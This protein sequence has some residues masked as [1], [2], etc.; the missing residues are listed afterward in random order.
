MNQIIY[1]LVSLLLFSLITSKNTLLEFLS[2]KNNKK[3]INKFNCARE[4]E[5][6]SFTSDCCPDLNCSMYGKC[7]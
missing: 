6:C 7:Y 5:Y 4:Q 2:E 3:I 1:L